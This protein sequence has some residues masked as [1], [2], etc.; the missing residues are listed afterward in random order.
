M[1]SKGN[2]S[3]GGCLGVGIAFFVILFLPA[4]VT[5]DSFGLGVL[6]VWWLIL[7]AI[8]FCIH[9]ANLSS[10]NN[11]ASSTIQR[12]VPDNN[13]QTK[14]LGKCSD[15]SIS[16]GS[17]EVLSSQLN[18]S[19]M[20]GYFS[21]FQLRDKLT[22][23]V[24]SLKQEQKG[25]DK[26]IEM[27]KK[28]QD[29]LREGKGK[30]LFTSKKKWLLLKQ[31]EIE[32]LD[33][34]IA[35]L[36]EKFRETNNQILQ[37]E[38]QIDEL[39]FN[40]FDESNSAFETLKA[41]FEKV[42]KSCKVSGVP[43]LVDSSISNNQR[44]VDFKYVNYKTPPYGLLLDN[45]R[46]YFFPTGIWVFEGDARL[47]GVYKPKALQ[48]SFETKETMKQSYYRNMEIYDDTKVITKDIP[49]HTWLHTCKDGSPDL[50][51][52]YNPMSTY[53][54]KQEYYVECSFDL[55]ICGCKL[56]YAISSFDN[57]E[58]LE[59]AIKKYAKIKENKD[60]IPILLDLLSRCS[61]NQDIKSIREKVAIY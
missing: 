45:Y 21:K 26:T 59:K 25:I 44:E 40:L 18:K 27:I 3:G 51:Y 22:V 4:W 39:K 28:Q 12:A 57:C 29:N 7:A 42:K 33:Y 43:N 19:I 13:N 41:A 58:M 8:V 23:S 55:D 35:E 61:D 9:E 20:N 50:R 2:N 5:G 17:L 6:I 10:N 37:I 52:S 24:E 60:V 48:G 32:A 49:H 16:S 34:E 31:S 1:A 15:T 47:V 38:R 56:K 11:P 30:T 53:Y 14:V 46:F 54:T 36:K